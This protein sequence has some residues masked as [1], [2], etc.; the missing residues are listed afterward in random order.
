MQFSA[1]TPTFVFMDAKVSRDRALSNSQMQRFTISYHWE[2]ALHPIHLE[3]HGDRNSVP[4][5]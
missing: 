3:I 4:E 5:A 1:A 2:M